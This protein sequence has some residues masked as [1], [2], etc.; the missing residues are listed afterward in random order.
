MKFST[1]ALAS[2][3]AL[4]ST[5]AFS[6][7]YT[8]E[9]LPLDA[10]A[11]NHFAQAITND[12][13]MLVSVQ[14]EFS[15]PIDLSLLDF[16]SES[17][18]ALLTDPDAAAA[19]NFNTEDYT[20]LV[21]L[22]ISGRSANSLFLQRLA[23]YRTYTTD[24]VANNLIPVFDI[25]TDTFDDYTQSANT[26]GRDALNGDV[27]VGNGV[28]PFFT[29]PY[30]NADGDDVTFVLNDFL[31]LGFVS[32]NGVATKLLSVEQTLGGYSE[33]FAIN[34]NMQV[35]GYGATQISE[36]TQGAIDNC[37]DADTRGD[38]PE[39]VCLRNIREIGTGLGDA[40]RLSSNTRPH[41][42]QLDN[43]GTVISTTT[44]GMIFEPD[45]DD[46]FSYQSRAFDIND[47]GI[48][49]GDSMTGEGVLITRPGSSFG[50]TE[51]ENVAVMYQNDMV[52]EILPR[53]E[54]QLSSARLINDDY[55]VGTVTRESNGVSRATLFVH[56]ISTQETTYPDGF[57]V[58]AGTT[59]RAI[60]NN[61]IIVGESEVEATSEVVREKNAFMYN[62]ET[63]EFLNLN[64]LIEC[65]SPYTLVDAV[66]INDN[67]EILVNARIRAP[68]KN[69][70]GE[71]VLNDA[72]ETTPVDT[73]YAVKLSPIPNGEIDDCQN[74]VVPVERQ[75]ASLGFGLVMLLLGVV[76]LRRRVAKS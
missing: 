31:S 64:R 45:A 38:I 3:L 15:P 22:L 74:I 10:I 62:I 18:R 2:S 50:T 6:A 54:N 30:V 52:T 16:E 29:L 33:A 59:P 49:V 72:G 71:N 26:V 73:V 47:A 5:T 7:Q 20:T 36:G 12:G 44:Y 32:V 19:G 24:G 76:G 42:W 23:Q 68:Q 56:N 61:N 41:I 40:L 21:N 69:I 60:N 37:A 28:A 1:L 13:T 70:I 57:F 53:E 35:A 27:I 46:T 63:G 14:D 17:L 67:N 34:S 65:D 51:A 48:A 25:V 11:V 43:D 4:A 75:G 9:P 66:D 55:I 39:E 58:N 8:L